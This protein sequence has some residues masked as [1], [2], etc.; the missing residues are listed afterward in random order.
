MFCCAIFTFCFGFTKTCLVH[1]PAG[2]DW[3]DKKSICNKFQQTTPVT[4]VTCLCWPNGRF[5]DLV[6]GVAEGKVKVGS[7]KTNK[8]TT[9]YSTDSYVVSLAASADG[10]GNPSSTLHTT[11]GRRTVSSSRHPDPAAPPPPACSGLL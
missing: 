9:L 3:G 6:F 10:M 8:S 11:H 7:L 4:S 5:N 2:L 1:S